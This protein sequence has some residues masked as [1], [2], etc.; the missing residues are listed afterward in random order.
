MSHEEQRVAELLDKQDLG[1]L[2]A[3]E[4]T[5]LNDLLLASAAARRVF[6]QRLHIDARLAWEF[7]RVDRSLPPLDEGTTADGFLSYRESAGSTARKTEATYHTT[8]STHHAR[9]LP[10]PRRFDVVA[11]VIVLAIVGT[12][13]LF[14]VPA[15][16][17]EAAQDDP[18]ERDKN[19]HGSAEP[20][21]VLNHSFEVPTRDGP[22]SGSLAGWVPVR[23]TPET[24]LA[25]VRPTLDRFTPSAIEPYFSDASEHL[26]HIYHGGPGALWQP[27]AGEDGKPKT[28][29]DP[30]LEAGVTYTLSVL[31]GQQ[32]AETP[33]RK[34]GFQPRP[35]KGCDIA[36][37]AGAK[38]QRDILPGGTGATLA[39]TNVPEPGPDQFIRAEV[40]F[41]C[42]ADDPRIGQPLSIALSAHD[43][44]HAVTYFDD[45]R[46]TAAQKE[47][48]SY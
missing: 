1:D 48:P 45:V 16:F 5:E 20:L 34:G 29:D 22:H 17:P 39:T 13:V 32:I 36:L 25:V 8:P 46:V 30:V 23:N 38:N 12:G 21:R 15:F 4:R 28:A 44:D 40:S 27:L 7:G 35:F 26:A 41:T 33:D 10:F 37:L 9:R 11:A 43:G 3:Q 18:V 19:E 31:V 14:V 6:R 47:A 24:V 2:N 42:S